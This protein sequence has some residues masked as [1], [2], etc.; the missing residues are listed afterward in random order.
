MRPKK[1]TGDPDRGW[2]RQE[3]LLL[4]VLFSD[5]GNAAQKLGLPDGTPILLCRVSGDRTTLQALREYFHDLQPQL[6][7]CL[8]EKALALLFSG[9][10]SCSGAE[11]VLRSAA[12]AFP[13]CLFCVG[14]VFH[15]VFSL[16]WEYE[17]LIS[18]A[19]S[20]WFF[21]KKDQRIYFS[22]C[23]SSDKG[24]EPVPEE[25]EI[26]GRLAACMIAGQK[27]AIGTVLHLLMNTLRADSSAGVLPTLRKL[28]CI[29][30]LISSQLSVRDS[31]IS[32]LLSDTAADMLLCSSLEACLYRLHTDLMTVLS[33]LN[34]PA[35]R[36]VV[37]QLVHHISRHYMEPLQLKSLSPEFGY[38]SVYLGKLFRQKTGMSFHSYLNRIRIEH[39]LEMLASGMRVT[40]VAEKCGYSGIHSFSRRFT[41]LVGCSPGV[42]RAQCLEM[43]SDPPATV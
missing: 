22:E 43:V 29:A 13:Q 14:S 34:R 17:K 9:I 18:F 5:G 2:L 6:F 10:S 7:F 11:T 8:T 24:K 16:P 35:E 19:D 12:D 40:D 3:E 1:A 23:V 26:A 28:Q 4:S 32:S 42:Y 20:R 31:R 37:Q 15:D 25:K 36:D 33:I 21:E 41:E 38:E 30:N 39:A 27:E